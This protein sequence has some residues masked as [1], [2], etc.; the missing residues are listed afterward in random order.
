M[1]NKREVN[2]TIL[3]YGMCPFKICWLR[4]ILKKDL[5]HCVRQIHVSGLKYRH[6][7]G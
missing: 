1:A 5:G 2:L 4:R 7:D 3:F 6:R